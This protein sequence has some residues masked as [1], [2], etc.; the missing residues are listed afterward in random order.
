M[1]ERNYTPTRLLPGDQAPYFV[2]RSSNNDHFKFSIAAGRYV[3]LCFFG[4]AKLPDI[5]TALKMLLS[6]RDL[7]DDDKVTFFGVSIGPDDEREGRFRQSLPGIRAIWDFDQ[8][9]SRLYGAVPEVEHSG[10]ENRVAYRPFV[11]VL[12][13]SLRVMKNLPFASDYIAELISYTRA[14]PDVN[15][16]AGVNVHAP[17][18]IIP[19]I[20]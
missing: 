2:V 8:R 1:V 4:S 19:R 16:H 18:L 10:E 14:L 3:V 17:V 11:L 7:F 20:F 15:Q 6:Q 9:V 12:D 5:E 13:P